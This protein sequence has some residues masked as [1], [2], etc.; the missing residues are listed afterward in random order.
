MRP[1]QMLDLQGQYQ[2]IKQEIDQKIQE[3]LAS[4]RF[5]N[6]DAVYSFQLHLENYLNIK[7]VIPCAN[8]TDALQIALMSL[9]L[10]AG[11]EV[12]TTP[13]TFIAAAEVVA[14]LGLRPVFAD[15]DFDTYNIDI[16]QIEKHITKK[17]KAI[18]PVHLF[19]QCCDMES[20]LS[21]AE[22]YHL[23]VIED[24]CQAIGAEFTFSNGQSKK[25]G[26]MG[27][28]GCVSFFPS[29]NLGCYGDGG[30]IFTSDDTLAQKM[31]TIANHGASIKYHHDLLGVNSRLDSIQAAILD[32]KLSYLD[33]YNQIRRE[34]AADYRQALSDCSNYKLPAEARNS[35]HVY[36]QYTLKLQHMD[37]NLWMEKLKAE[38]IPTTIYYP[39]PLHLQK[40]FQF[41]E[42]KKGDF[43]IAE[44]LCRTVVSLPMH[45]ELDKEQLQWIIKQMK[46]IYILLN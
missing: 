38:K 16:K 41:L 14:F 10:Q 18:L 8:G 2:K 21:L 26:T 17:T 46:K 3:V 42:Y 12:I 44:E 31:R 29:K 24:A 15:V 22:K 34:V 27:H 35:T 7:H 40:V 37:R 25:A 13:F 1:I 36:H 6:G 9:N 4:A 23:F 43:P 5:I 32:V 20:V 33:K 30:A 45:T 19:G 28:I 39:V 11:D